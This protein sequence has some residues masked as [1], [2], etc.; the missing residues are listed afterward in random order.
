[1]PVH[2]WLAYASMWL[3]HSPVVM[4]MTGACVQA[5]ALEEDKCLRFLCRMQ[6]DTH[7]LLMASID[8]SE[9]IV[10]LTALLSV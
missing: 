4:L 2:V 9:L 10:G 6:A 7:A 8:S 1:M 5:L 3:A